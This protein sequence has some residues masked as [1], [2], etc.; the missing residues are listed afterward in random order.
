MAKYG[1]NTPQAVAILRGINTTSGFTLIQGPPGTGKSHTILGLI[2]ALLAQKSEFAP[3][4]LLVCGPS[5]AAVDEIVKRLLQGIPGRDGKKYVPRIVRVGAS[6]SISREVR[7]VTL[8][9]LI[10]QRLS[11]PAALMSGGFMATQDGALGKMGDTAAALAQAVE[12]RNRLREE[13]AKLENDTKA[14]VEQLRR[15]REKFDAASQRKESLGREMDTLREQQR[16]AGKA[17]DKMRKQVRNQILRETEILCCTLSS[18]GHE[19]L[20][21]MNTTFET[22][23]IDEAA[24]SV[25][26]DSLIPLKYGCRRCILVGDPN[27][28]PPTV[29]SQAAQRKGYDQSLFVRLQRRN[30]S[31]VHLLSIQYRMHPAISALPSRMFYNS[32]LTDGPG[33]AVTQTAPWHSDAASRFPPF[34]FFDVSEGRSHATHTGAQFNELECE[35]A[36]QLVESLCMSF[37]QIDFCRRIGIITPY[38][39]QRANIANLLISRFGHAVSAAIDVNTIDGF[40]GQEKDIIIFSCVRA[41]H[42][43][44]GFLKDRR[45]INV[46]LTRARKSLFVLGNA[47]F[48]RKDDLWGQ[49]VDDARA[50]NAI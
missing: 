14:E 47:E 35:I 3:N 50:R 22:V 7:S 6:E 32:Q 4:K 15:A 43:G 21:G 39:K 36:V 27:Q 42:E 26:L 24:Q 45:R 13:L 49:L 30:P 23:I 29:L 33:L 1:V 17:L 25:E 31:A 8:D 10:E 41:S 11:N 2:G 18:S 37:P 28:L 5:N 19:M 48:L 44:I 46:A 9:T 38:R 20:A 40:Q 12:E 34:R 16:N